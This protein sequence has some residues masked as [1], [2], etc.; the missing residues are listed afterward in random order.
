[1][2]L[3]CI[4]LAGFKSFVDP[5]TVNFPSYL[6]A[7]VGP[8]GCGKSNIIDAVRWVM[9]ESSAKQL[10]GESM[11]DV[12]FNG[13]SGRKPVGQASIELVF[14]NADGGL[15]GEY[16]AYSEISIRRKV[17]RDGQSNYYLNGNKCRR[18]DITDVFLGT[19]LGPRSYAIIEQ[20][21]ISNVIE[22]RPEELRV[23]IEEAAGISKYRERR[24]ETESRIART[25]ENLERLTDIRDELARQLQRLERQA[26][27]AEKYTQYKRE[28][29]QLK[30]QLLALRWRDYDS[31]GAATRKAIAE[32]ELKVEAL[33]AE[34][35]GCDTRIEKRRL[36]HTAQTDAFNQIQ[37]N[38]Y[39]I[40]AE[41]ARL[42]Q[43]IQ[44][45][46]ERIQALERDLAQT[47]RNWT[48]STEHLQ[49]DRQKRAGW[50]AEIRELEP[51]LHRARELEAAT[52][53]ELAAAETAMQAWQK[54]WDEFSE[55]AAAPPRQAEVQQ[56]RIQQLE[57]GLRRLGERINN[58][59]QSYAALEATPA[60]DGSADLAQQLAATEALGTAKQAQLQ[61][62]V[63][64]IDSH[65]KASIE[66]ARHLAA[67]REKMHRLRGRQSSLEALQQAALT[68]D[69][70]QVRW[71]AEQGLAATAR[72]A[73]A[74]Q[75]ASGWETAVETVLGDYL[76]AVWVDNLEPFLDR[77]RGL[78]SGNL[79]LVE[80][81]LD[82]AASH[83]TG[84]DLAAQVGE[85][86]ARRLLHGVYAADSL[87]AALGVRTRLGEGESV[88]TRD[89]LWLG[90]NWVR[91]AR[92]TDA[93][94]GILERKRELSE[95]A[96]QLGTVQREVDT[97]LAA[98]SAAEIE[99]A[100]LEQVREAI[101]RDIAVQQRQYA[102]LRSRFS[103]EKARAEQLAVRR[104]TLKQ[105][106]A[107][108][109]A[110]QKQEQ[111]HLAAARQLL[112]QALDA[113]ALD[114]QRRKQLQRERDSC[115]ARLDDIRTLARQHRDRAHEL[116]LRQQSVS[117]QLTSIRAGIER[118]EV[119]V[120][121]LS[122]RRAALE[123]SVGEQRDPTVELE[124]SLQ[125]KLGSR[126]QVETALTDARA[127][128]DATEQDVRALER[129]RSGLE[130]QLQDQRTTLEQ[131]RLAAQ[132][133][134]TRCSTL[135]EQVAEQDFELPALLALLPE[136]ADPDQWEQQLG[137]IDSRIQRL[138]PINLAA[139][140][141]YQ[142][143]SERKNYLDAQH[144]ELADALATLEEAIRKIDRETR[145]RFKET[146]DQVNKTLQE[147]FPK[148]FGGGH[149]YLELTGSDLLN[150]GVTIM[151]QP[152]GK[153][154]A[155]IH[156]LSG[157]EKALT[158]IALVFAL[159]HLNPA[160][161]C[162][163][164]E[165]DAPL[166]DANV[167]RFARL[168]KEMSAKIQL[169]YITHNKIAMEMAHQLMGVTMS[170]PGVSR[171]VSVDVDR[172]VQLAQS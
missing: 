140:D 109:S 5:T 31:A 4:K 152:P 162:M 78:K 161:F 69:K 94:T 46:R 171:L 53:A 118:L 148:L 9:G 57:Q 166:D 130:Q 98:Q 17:T 172:A 158:A 91:V 157:G 93:G 145:T 120:A 48:E 82:R 138:G 154:N 107:E 70:G 62:A 117:A 95:V 41:V 44:H 26:Q 68:G 81:G 149:A 25:R 156:L 125:E 100:R 20:G 115:R 75:V 146:F 153:K 13:S 163:L 147:L 133:L 50:E 40:G 55:A 65:R 39:A 16:G 52:A 79:A 3:K 105:D 170:E 121:R 14:D 73:D 36:E 32:E 90:S 89:G 134:V 135:A 84:S 86:P 126:L 18:R 169:I 123:A 77:L 137:Q 124:R 143:E 49:A 155:T 128:V 129:Q 64:S 97:Q 23:F 60:V 29:R 66:I 47:A 127:A 6:C 104:Q 33:L 103:A 12:I 141:E 34:R 28:E 131:Q 150:T 160:P 76:Q 114:D 136:G 8:N 19:G 92:G 21:M 74:I 108:A 58:Q 1:M 54:Q 139:V 51:D 27:A 168:V 42:E 22:S 10:R 63:A 45:S 106:L 112:A 151:A 43:S 38:Y 67:A 56:S 83:H 71:L 80:P 7:V 159:F 122:E 164:D 119:Q 167:V 11:A 61:E 30:A 96:T 99:L 15:G 101:A 59:N 111:V 85:G 113:M 24:K 110:Q 142:T 87:A 72:I 144:S 165:V 35:A 116:A 132:E 2:H 37:S 88:V 102:D